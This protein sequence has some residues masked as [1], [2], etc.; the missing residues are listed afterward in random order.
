[1]A[2]R[3]LDEAD[4]QILPPGHEAHEIGDE[5][6]MAASKFISD[7]GRREKA[8]RILLAGVE[9]PL[10]DRLMNSAEGTWGTTIHYADTVRGLEELLRGA[11]RE[12][13]IERIPAYMEARGKWSGDPLTWVES[14]LREGEEL[15]AEKVA[16]PLLTSGDAPQ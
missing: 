3:L 1:M 8:Y 12:D 4:G 16:N 14:L 15:V 9:Q 10:H 6:L 13:L 2:R 11:D 5:D 7:Y